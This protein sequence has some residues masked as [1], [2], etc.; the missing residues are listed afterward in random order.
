MTHQEPLD[1]DEKSLHRLRTASNYFMANFYMLSLAREGKF[2]LSELPNRLK[3]KAGGY[4]RIFE[5]GNGKPDLRAYTRDNLIIAF[6]VAITMLDAEFKARF[7][8]KRLNDQDADRRAVR[9]IAYQIRNAFTHD[10]LTPTWSVFP[11]YRREYSIQKLGID[12]DL[13]DAYGQ[14]LVTQMEELVT[15]HEI[16]GFSKQYFGEPYV[17]QKISKDVS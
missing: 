8:S 7:K 4:S 13:R 6:G 1:A 9:C 3:V 10:P 14:P 11:D 12:L 16:I 5:Y 15:L 2:D 17:P